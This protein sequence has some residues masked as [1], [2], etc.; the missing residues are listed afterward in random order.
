LTYAVSVGGRRGIRRAKLARPGREQPKS[1]RSALAG[2][3]KDEG[4]APLRPRQ[5]AIPGGCRCTVINQ[6]IYGHIHM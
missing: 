1:G 3:E 2:P 5:P 4:Y 6:P